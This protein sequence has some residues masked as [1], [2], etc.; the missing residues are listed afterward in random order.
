MPKSPIADAAMAGLLALRGEWPEGARK[1][2]RASRN[3]RS[4]APERRISTISGPS[5]QSGSR[6][7]RRIDLFQWVEVEG[8][9]DFAD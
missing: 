5:R 2:S 6:Q 3:A 1:R 8:S 9:A 7:A 4:A